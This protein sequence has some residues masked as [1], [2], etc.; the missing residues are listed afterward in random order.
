MHLHY[1][2]FTHQI[3]GHR[4]NGEGKKKEHEQEQEPELQSHLLETK[5]ERG[6]KRIEQVESRRLF[7]AHLTINYSLNT[8]KSQNTWL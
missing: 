3:I 8:L 7:T 2:Y 5:N 4:Q 6:K 1:S